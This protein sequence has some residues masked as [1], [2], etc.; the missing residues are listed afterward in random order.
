MK[1]EPRTNE[2]ND[3]HDQG[4]GAAAAVGESARDQGNVWFVDKPAK[5]DLRPTMNP[6]ALVER[7]GPQLQQD[8]RRGARPVRRFGYYT[9]RLRKDGPTGAP[10]RSRP[11]VLRHDR[12]ALAGLDGKAGGAEQ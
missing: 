6:V 9:D 7:A 3:R 1:R 8:P 5:N 11:E 4:A 2:G 10:R 12:Q